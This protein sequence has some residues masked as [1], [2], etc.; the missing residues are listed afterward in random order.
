MNSDI[1][2]DHQHWMRIALEEAERAM[3]SG[4]LPIAAILVSNS[5][6]VIREQTQVSRMGSMT[7]HGE[8]LAL[9]R[10]GT[11]LFAGSKPLILY[12]N[13][14]P[15]LMCLGAA[16]QCGVDEIV[17]GMDCAP[18]G[19]IRYV[20]CIKQGGQ[21]TPRITRQV[22]EAGSV[23]LFRRFLLNN[24][25]HFAVNYVRALLEPYTGR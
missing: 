10:A 5:E 24:P 20:D 4:E 15:C 18:D 8:V 17:Y 21:T 23:E 12:T 16:M 25:S 6:E 3:G 22:R 9:M 1:H 14:E 7:A 11:K 19:G 13:L 2:L